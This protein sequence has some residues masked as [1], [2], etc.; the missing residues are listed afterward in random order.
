MGIPTPIL[1]KLFDCDTPAPWPNRERL[2]LLFRL[3]SRRSSSIF[4]VVK[5]VNRTQQRTNCRQDLDDTMV[6]CLR[7]ALN[8]EKDTYSARHN[9]VPPIV[10]EAE[11]S[12]IRCETKSQTSNVGF[13]HDARDKVEKSEFLYEIFLIYG[14]NMEFLNEL[15]NETARI[16]LFVMQDSGFASRKIAEICQTNNLNVGETD[17]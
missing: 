6:S 3:I 5:C 16:E 15:E 17:S 2:K 4:Q 11:N 13:R 14:D 8:I 9:Y 10:I 12:Q 7:E 1:Y